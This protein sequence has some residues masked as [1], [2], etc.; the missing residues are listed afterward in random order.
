MILVI[1]DNYEQIIENKDYYDGI[2]LSIDKFSVN[3]RYKVNLNEL[4]D[5]I[6]K[7]DNKEIFVSVNKNI[8]NNELEELEKLLINLNHYNIKGLFYADISVLTYKDKLNYKLI[9]SHEHMTTNYETI[10]YWN[11]L[12]AS[13]VH[14]SSD[15][16][17]EETIEIIRKSKTTN[18]VNLFGYLPMFVSK[19]HIVKNY[20]EYFNIKD[21]SD[22][23][24]M[25]KEGKIYPIIDDDYTYVFTNN[26]YNGVIEYFNIKP[27]YYICNGTFLD[28]LDF[29]KVLKLINSINKDNLVDINKRINDMFLNIDT[30][31]L[32]KK[33]VSRI[34]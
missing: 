21:N 17:K 10:N 18:F 27:D 12:G 30:G 9:Y 20:L 24:Y 13:G 29:T 34:K 7:L 14:I 19:R 11:E 2:I 32:Y 15:I 31:F 4:K 28:N 3:S 5:I 26:I 16:T 1:P 8:E 22:V 23:Y 6:D 33:T 25:K